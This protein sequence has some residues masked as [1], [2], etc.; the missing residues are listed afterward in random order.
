MSY[1]F[2]RKQQKISGFVAYSL[3]FILTI[4]IGLSL[5]S[6]KTKTAIQASQK[7]LL[8]DLRIS[9]ITA[10]S[11]TISFFT[12]KPTIAYVSAQADI[13]SEPRIGFDFDDGKKLKERVLHY[14]TFDN[15]LPNTRYTYKV[16]LS[17]KE[18]LSH[19]DYAFRTIAKHLQGSKSS[20]QPFFGKVLSVNLQPAENTLIYLSFPTINPS[21]WYSAMSK[22]TG[23]WVI[24]VPL[25]YSPNFTPRELTDDN[26]VLMRFAQSTINTSNIRVTIKHM[27]P[28]KTV[29]LGE[30]FDT[31]QNT[32]P[33]TESVRGAADSSTDVL[34]IL[35]P[36]TGSILSSQYPVIQGVAAPN[37]LINMRLDPLSFRA[38]LNT[39]RNGEWRYVS[40][41]PLVPG[42]YVF[43]AE[44]DNINKTI[45]FVIGKSGESVLGNATAS[46]SLTPTQAIGS[47]GGFVTP[48]SIPTLP[49]PTVISRSIPTAGGN[50]NLIIGIAS[51]L[52]LLGLIFV[53]Y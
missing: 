26:E 30:S 3:L 18:P 33:S 45:S 17:R 53:L 34:R 12:E 46:A 11:A 22:N 27:S 5:R 8:H 50:T 23:E 28:L 42:S 9:N 15:L 47:V 41:K 31:R 36:L 44:Q 10:T 49:A 7:I 52:S 29:I 4:G 2:L 48:T 35:S 38:V 13:V 19:K 39:N 14:I 20:T 37:S 43:I 51:G 40:N 32:V 16:Y 6:I 25:V 21:L 1:Y 24:T